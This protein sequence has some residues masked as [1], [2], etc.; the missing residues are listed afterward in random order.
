[1]LKTAA[2]STP[3]NTIYDYNI[4]RWGAE[5]FQISEKGEIV[6]F[7]VKDQGPGLS[8]HEVLQDAMTRGWRTPLLVRF[9]DLLRHRVKTINEAFAGAI[10]D[11]GYQGRYRG[12]FP[13]KVNQLREVVE[14]I[15]DAGAPYHFGI[16]VGSKPE[17]YAALAVH[18]D[19]ESLI[20]CNGYK[21]S[22][23]IRMALLGR[24]LG[25]EVIMVVEK[26][27][28][29]HR[30]V[31]L[32]ASL[33]VEPHIGIR[34]RLQTKG[35]G[36]WALSG[37]DNAKFGLSTSDLL[38]AA[39]LLKARGMA[40]SLRLLHFHVGSQIPDILTIKKAV[41]EAARN[42]AKLHQLGFHLKYLDVGG[43][44]GVDYD[45]SRTDGEN[46]TNYTLEEY[47]RDVVHNIKE[48]CA[49]EKVP[50]PNIVSEGGRAVVAHHS[51]LLVEVFGAIEKTRGPAPV[52][53]PGDHKLA[54]DLCGLLQTLNKRNRREHLHQALQIREE[55]MNRFGLGLLD[56]HSKAKIETAYWHLIEKIVGLFDGIKS[57]PCE[58]RELEDQL[59]DQ[60]LCNFSVFQS[61]I[62]H[63]ALDQLFP[64]APIHRLN[65]EPEHKAT[66][67]DITCDS[68]GKIDRFILD[69]TVRKTIPLH[70]LN[71]KPYYL[72]LFLMGAYQ[73]VMGDLHNLFGPVTEVHVFLDNEEPSG[74]YIEEVIPGY[75]IG[76]VLSDVQYEPNVL[77][78]QMKAQIDAAIKS[79]LLKPSDGMQWLDAYEKGLQRPTY[80]QFD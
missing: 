26:I 30:I 32:A 39:E 46:S 42:Y 58:V 28:E 65:E 77:C 74:Y 25:K 57:I 63:W 69:D 62:D 59:G 53:E 12:V 22:E 47:T 49:E 29:L 6:A 54:E 7:P 5:Y 80:L 34:I 56:L 40:D 60:F 78:R 24:K 76:Q 21:D 3:A 70:P 67:V 45:G 50:H 66:L 19:P 18:T 11:L 38:E 33:N 71:G 43:G 27:E 9:Q 15:L 75:T 13:I 48:I 41:R 36:K 31:E 68:D 2:G 64:I 23:F 10:T 52:A 79:N 16:E 17:L 35:A 61:L 4:Q 14:E 55:A 51:V 72:G 1:M 37:G 20:I 8:I 73:D 44:L